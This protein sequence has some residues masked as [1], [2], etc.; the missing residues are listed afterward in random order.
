M[1]LGFQNDKALLSCFSTII[2]T[3]AARIRTEASLPAPTDR[4]A[5][6]V[7]AGERVWVVVPVGQRRVVRRQADGL[8]VKRERYVVIELHQG[9]VSYHPAADTPPVTTITDMPPFCGTYP[10]FFSEN[11]YQ[12]VSFRHIPR[13][14]SR[15]NARNTVL[16]F[17]ISAEVVAPADAIASRYAVMR[18]LA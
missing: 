4:H 15:H 13:K 9:Q 12:S 6:A 2:P 8:D 7:D 14:T 17:I 3:L 11:P 1:W 18:S 10:Y 16:L 5:V